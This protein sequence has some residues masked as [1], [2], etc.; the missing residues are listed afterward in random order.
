MTIAQTSPAEP[1]QRDDAVR[2]AQPAA[3]NGVQER[4][5]MCRGPYGDGRADPG[6]LPVLDPRAGPD[7]GPGRRWRVIHV[8]EA[9]PVV[10]RPA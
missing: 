4:H 7:H 2:G 6:A 5:C 3:A 9:S 8:G 1:A 10:G